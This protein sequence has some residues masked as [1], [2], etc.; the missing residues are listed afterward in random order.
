MRKADQFSNREGHQGSKKSS[1][2]GRTNGGIVT[3]RIIKRKRKRTE[4][5]NEVEGAENTG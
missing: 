2:K 3:A 4:H 1:R 5:Q